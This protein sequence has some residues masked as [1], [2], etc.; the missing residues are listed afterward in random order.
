MHRP[1][2]RHPLSA[3]FP[4]YAPLLDKP[5]GLLGGDNDTP[6]ATGY[7]A[8][9]G[10]RATYAALSR[11]VFDVGAWDNCQWIVFHGASGHTGSPTYD[12]Q[13]A[14]WAA[15]TRSRHAQRHI[16]N[17]FRRDCSEGR[18]RFA[19]STSLSLL[20]CAK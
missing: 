11:Y 10:M 13:N 7:I 20:C 2:L 16:S 8:R 9:L 6:F 5:C 19:D 18:T 12:N 14:I 4:E 15:G 3:A 1:S 17:C